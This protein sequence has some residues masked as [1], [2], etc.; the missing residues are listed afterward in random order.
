M[1]PYNIL[2]ITTDQEQSFVDLPSNLNLP[3]R[4]RLQAKSVAFRKFQ[5]NTTPC[6]PSRSVIYTG[7]HT[8]KTGMFSNPNVPPHVHLPENMPT[9]GSMFRELGYYTVYKGKW[10]LS[11]MENNFH[12]QRFPTTINALEPW[13]FSEYTHDGDHHG[14]VWDGFKHDSSIAA[15]AAN[16]LLRLDGK[17]PDNKPWL[18]AVNFINPHDIMF[19]DATGSMAQQRVDPLRV[20]P[21]KPAPNASIYNTQL[22]LSLPNSFHDDLSKKPSAHRDD[23]QL[24]NVMYGPLPHDNEAAW[25]NHRNYY[26]NCIR[27]V[28]EH[29]GCVLNALQQSGQADQTIV[30][31]T[32]D[33]GEMAGAHGMRQKGP[34]MYKENI[35]VSLYID[36]PDF[37]A[38]ET[39]AL[40]SSV[41]LIPTLLEI[42]GVPESEQASRWPDLKGVSL[43]GALSGGNTDRDNRGML[44]DYTATLSWDVDLIATIFAGQA[45]GAFTDDEKARMASGLSL[46]NYA[47]FRGI[48]D[49]RYKFARYFKP[50]EHHTPEDWQTLSGHNELELYDTVEDPDEC[51]N[52]AENPGP[53]IRPLILSLN[54]KL[55]ELISTEIGV[56][57][58]SYY[59][60]GRDY[61]LATHS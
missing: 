43:T 20:A 51:N 6:G 38:G 58:G 48:N 60:P 26:Y 50:A 55:N 23:Q 45:R 54:A 52:L 25:H 56:D 11:E 8:Q 41:D 16:W 59:P 3:N 32:S 1:Q 27:D 14:I 37:S 12:A 17:Q 44:V 34:S 30:V 39:D 40:A 57:D 5:V 33:H 9:L 22:G 31:F 4:Q 49:G 24:A 28:D 36:H 46:D 19:F 18:M 15:D 35:G 42:S 29:I 10:H 47:C 61:T 7:Q 21:L 13:G 53:N 2:F